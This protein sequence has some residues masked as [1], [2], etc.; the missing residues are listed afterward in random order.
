[1][2]KNIIISTFTVTNNRF[3]LYVS[4]TSVSI[5]NLMYFEQFVKNNLNIKYIFIYKNVDQFSNNTQ[6]E[7]SLIRKDFTKIYLIL[8][9]ASFSNLIQENQNNL[10]FQEFKIWLNNQLVIFIGLTWNEALIEFEKHNINITI[11]PT[12]KKFILRSHE[13]RL[14]N[15]CYFL[16][17]NENAIFEG[18]K[19]KSLIKIPIKKIVSKP[20]IKEKNIIYFENIIPVESVIKSEAKPLSLTLKKD[21]NLIK[22]EPNKDILLIEAPKELIIKESKIEPKIES[23]PVIKPIIESKLIIESKSEIPKV[24]SKLKKYT[25]YVQLFSILLSGL[26]I[27]FVFKEIKYLLFLNEVE[28]FFI[29]TELKTFV[30]KVLIFITKLLI[31]ITKFLMFITKILENILIFFI[32]SLNK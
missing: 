13:Y 23:K 29:L 27:F 8:S 1:M 6:N 32:N 21:E 28:L 7:K 25:K 5:F 3:N 17:V 31:L 20:K 11:G 9:I 12:N 2:N 22:S 14:S 26:L 15:I 19:D 18:S 4:I 24:H 30:I 16:N 10:S